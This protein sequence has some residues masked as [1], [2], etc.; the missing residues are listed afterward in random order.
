MS[1]VAEYLQE[2]ILGEV[3]TN[4]AILD[5][6][7][8]DASMLQ[9]RPEIVVYPRLT[10]DIRKVARFAWQLAEKGHTM[11]ITIRG[12]GTDT[13]GG[14]IG[15][16]VILSTK[17]HM[18]ALLEF[19]QKQ[20]LI[21]VQSGLTT[22]TL[23]AAL[24]L[25]G[26]GIP[27]F[28]GMSQ[29]GTVGGAVG[30]DAGGI[31]A[32]SVGTARDWTHQLEV[33]LAN[34]DVLQTERIS[35]RELNK[36]KGLQT[37]EG[38][39]YRGIDGLIEDNKQ[40]IEQHIGIDTPDTSGYSG[41]AKVKQRDGSFDLTPLFLGSQ[42]TLGIVSE[43]ILKCDYISM[44]QAVTVAVFESKEAARDTLDQLRGFEPAFLD[45]YD[46]QLFNAAARRGKKYP[47]YNESIQAIVVLGFTDFSERARHKKQKKVT[48]LLD[49]L[50]ISHTVAN[51]EEAKTLAEVLEVTA[52]TILPQEKDTSAPPLLDGAYV[53]PERFEEFS[54]SLV[55]LAAQHHVELPIH[56]NAL[57]STVFVRPSFQLHKVGDK[58]KA[59][60]LLDEYSALV[61][62]L[63]GCPA[64]LG[65]EG[66]LKVSSA[67]ANADI[68]ELYTAI[69]SLFDPYVI[70]N[71]GVKQ[72]TDTRQLV[73]LLRKDYDTTLF[74]DEVA[75]N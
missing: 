58:Q 69:K 29:Y 49:K 30:K 32:G 18:N 23:N 56:L 70:L 46:G 12:G 62:A 59:F 40:L 48:K 45:Y 47:F 6:M 66:R 5:A 20:K 64:A 53:P 50:Q 41:I 14:A 44:H 38:E 51:G 22:A 75:F 8:H 21:R 1:K 27:A 36:R 52:F 9:A 19:D 26:M 43:L 72:T 68:Q 74:K 57:S 61:I 60:K 71:P 16:G 25:Q 3:V 11:P 37:F 39:V 35:K 17:A 73:A 63:G 13:T 42:G 33:V 2:H 15:N 24:A 28:T 34:G 10:N 65:G 55:E 31:L 54:R 7:S 67:Q 4:S